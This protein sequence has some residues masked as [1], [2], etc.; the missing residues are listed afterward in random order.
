[1]TEGSEF[2][3]AFVEQTA[4]DNHKG[5]TFT[6]AQVTQVCWHCGREHLEH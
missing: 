1:M 3:F 4:A 5:R 2:H 6:D